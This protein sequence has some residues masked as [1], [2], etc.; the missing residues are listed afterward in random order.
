MMDKI[1]Y[2]KTPHIPQSPGV[3]RDDRVLK[4]LSYFD[5]QEV[6]ITEKMDGENTT[7]SKDFIHARSVDSQDHPSRHYIKG[8]WGGIRYMIPD[9]IRICGENLYA[10][11]SIYYEDLRDYFYVFNMWEGR[12]CYSWDNTIKIANKLGL[13]LVPVL[14]RGNFDKDKLM[15]IINNLDTDKQEGVVIRNVQSFDYDNFGYNVA[16][17]VRDKHVQT[18]E[19]WM[20]KPIVKNKLKKE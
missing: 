13:E 14:Y 5:N 17:W 7:M 18:D 6:V 16:K 20:N 2:P 8:L 12:W 1:K 10:M 15:E 4:G 9:N 3:H 19:H 11:H